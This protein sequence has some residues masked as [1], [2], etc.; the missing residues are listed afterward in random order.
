MFLHIWS[1]V[2][3]QMWSMTLL[4]CGRNKSNH[5]NS[6]PCGSLLHFLVLDRFG[7]LIIKGS[8]L[9]SVFNQKKIWVKIQHQM[10]VLNP[11]YMT[12]NITT[13]TKMTKRQIF[14][15]FILHCLMKRDGVDR[16]FPF[17]K[18]DIIEWGSRYE[19]KNN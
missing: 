5:E 1:I 14:W 16:M 4:W 15:I 3:G 19:P 13:L 9:F 7:G 11:I 18:W 10:E 12:P 8:A 2:S 6:V 17:A